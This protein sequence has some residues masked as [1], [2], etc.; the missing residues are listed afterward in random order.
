MLE[1]REAS[2][3]IN[4]TTLLQPVS[5]AFAGGCVH[6]LIGHNGSGK[7]TLLNL[8]ARQQIPSSGTVWLDGTDVRRWPGRAFARRVAYLPQ[9]LPAAENLTVRELVAFGRY[10]WHGLLG[11]A[12]RAD[13]QAIDRALEQTGTTPLTDRLVDT[14]SGG[15]RQRAWLAMLLAQE[16]DYLLL[17][18]PL[19]ALDIAHQVEVLALIR[20]LA[21]DMGLGVVVVL[22][23]INM[24]ARYCDTLTALQ[25]GEVI[26]RG[27]P[28][29]LMQDATL[30][31]IY[32]IP[33]QVMA[34]PGGAHR[35]AVV[36]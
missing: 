1:T 20:D 19:A 9:R 18:E 16:S 7:T 10:P 34:H 12:T 14:L 26:A 3:R 31:A 30:K 2:V 21:R 27:A 35:V 6:G 25:G 32:G 8:L 17:D 28:T 23:D 15:E 22:H 11:R 13:R 24:A 29:E 5:D 36:E 33:M 4:G